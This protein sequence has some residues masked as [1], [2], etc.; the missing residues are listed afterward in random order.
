MTRILASTV[1]V[2]ALAL[3][4]SA[5]GAGLKDALQEKGDY[6]TFLEAVEASDAGWF[7]EEDMAY[8]AFVPTDEAFA[9]LPDGVLDALMKPENKPKLNA[10]L[11]H[12]I[13][14]EVVATAAE[15]SDGQS[16]DVADGEPLTVKVDGDTVMVDGAKVVEPDMEAENGI[17]HGIE[18]VLV[19]EI[20]VQA[21]KYTGDFPE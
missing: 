18:Q 20:V 11:E 17:A 14:P 5:W 8:T 10:I 3:G 15:V 12:H 16:L 7:L 13:V 2:V 1:A 6:S 21:M 19:P 9:A 4:S